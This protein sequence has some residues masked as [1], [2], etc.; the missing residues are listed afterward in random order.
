MKKGVILLLMLLL[1][2]ELVNAQQEIT[3]FGNTYPLILVAPIFLMAIMFLF[4]LGLI[5]K[6]NIGKI[7]LPKIKAKLKIKHEK[8]KIAKQIKLD[9]KTRFNLLKEKA[10]KI[11][12]Q[13]SFN[14]FNEIVKEFFKEKFHIKHEFTFSELGNIVKGHIKD[15]ELAN[16]ISTLRYSGVSLDSLQIRIL[17]KQFED[18]LKDYKFEEEKPE[19]GFWAGVR[20]NFLDIFRKKEIRLS[21]RELKIKAPLPVKILVEQVEVERVIKQPVTLKPV[22]RYKFVLFSNLLAKVQKFKILSLIENGKKALLVNP[23]LAKRYYARALLSYYKLPMKE[24]KE[25]VDKLME[26][27]NGILDLRSHEKTFLDI[28]KNL[29]EMKHQGKHISK[30]SLGLLST[31]KNFIEREELLATTKLKEFS[32]KLKHEERKLKHFIVKEKTGFIEGRIKGDLEKFGTAVTPI[33]HKVLKPEIAQKTINLIDQYKTKLDFL[34][35]QPKIKV[36]YEKIKHKVKPRI[37]SKQLRILQKQ[38]SELY[39]KLLEL[40]SGKLPHHKL[41]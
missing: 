19:L 33:E 26:L 18:L 38:R 4:F 5:I 25:I 14:E 24:E 3:L 40:E 16:K 17:F 29:I 7:K 32:N 10:S 39:N 31:L 36:E 12:A 41:N 37:M 34:Y 22:K 6:D 15:I 27:H 9:I 13:N 35:K 21:I 28:S 8:T 30:E 20:E 2:L 23:L 11:G 1:S